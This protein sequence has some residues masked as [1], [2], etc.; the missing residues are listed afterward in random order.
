MTLAG[1]EFAPCVVEVG[2]PAPAPEP[3]PLAGLRLDPTVP[4]DLA[5]I[6]ELQGRLVTFAGQRGDLTALIDVPPG[7]PRSRILVWRAGFDSARAAC[8]HPWL[9]VASPDDS[10]DWLVRVNPSAFAAGII[11]AREWR[12]G[13]AAGPANVV[14]AG[15]VRTAV[16]VPMFEHDELHPNGINVFV[17]ERD[18]VR[19]MGARTLSGL[20]SQRQLS[21]VRLTTVIALTLQ[22]EMVW[23][24][25][26]PNNEQLWGRV[27]RLVNDYLD[28]LHRQGAFAGATPPRLVLRALRSPVDDPG[29]HRRRPVRRRGR[30][31]ADRADRVHR[32]ALRRQ[33]RP[34]P[35]GRDRGQPW[36]SQTCCSRSTSG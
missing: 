31:R 23:A 22:R 1:D 33:R 18:G 25:F 36:L 24:A 3:Q 7:L 14:A 12:N 8:Y 17:T 4:G 26:E 30:V 2:S 5:R 10:R 11:A 9:D 28:G 32:G 20:H 19:L 27:R 35:A 15:V 34:R 13:V 6:A 21:V 29:R 16:P